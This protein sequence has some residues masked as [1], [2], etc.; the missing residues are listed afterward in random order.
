MTDTAPMDYIQP[1]V[2]TSCHNGADVYDAVAFPVVIGQMTL[3]LYIFSAFLESSFAQFIRMDAV[4]RSPVRNLTDVHASAAFMR[5]VIALLTL[6]LFAL[7]A[8]SM[9]VPHTAASPSAILCWVCWVVSAASIYSDLR[10]HLLR[11]TSILPD[12]VTAR[13][14]GAIPKSIMSIWTPELQA[15]RQRLSLHIDILLGS[16]S[17]VV[18]TID[19]INTS[20]LFVVASV[21]AS[22]HLAGMLFASLVVAKLAMSISVLIITGNVQSTPAL[23]CASVLGDGS[24]VFWG[25]R[26]DHNVLQLFPLSF[27][28]M[29]LNDGDIYY[30]VIACM[31]FQCTHKCIV[32]VVSVY[33]RQLV[34]DTGEIKL[35]P[36]AAETKKNADPVQQATQDTTGTSD[37]SITHADQAQQSQQA[38]QGADQDFNN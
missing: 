30:S 20:W 37:T 34:Q 17:Q 35:K 12:S 14:S 11:L 36:T 29:W 2:N 22:E 8:T 16:F 27:M 6:T 23:L 33:L 13:M 25:V 19:A 31:L 4:L 26:A 3:F 28:A 21:L 38:H 18:G 24:G 7:V 5:P 1:P 15:R 32:E 9:L 10:V